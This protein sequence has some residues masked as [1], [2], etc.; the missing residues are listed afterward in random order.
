MRFIPKTL[1][2][3]IS[4]KADFLYRRNPEGREFRNKLK[5]KGDLICDKIQRKIIEEN[6]Y[7][8]SFKIENPNFAIPFHTAKRSQRREFKKG[9]QN[10]KNAFQWGQENFDPSNFDEKFIRYLAA[11]IVPEIY[12]GDLAQYRKDTEGTGFSGDYRVTP[13]YPQKLTE[14]EIPRFV[15]KLQENFKNDRGIMARIKTSIDSHFHIARMHPFKDG[16]GRTARIF[17]DII[18][19]HYT[20]PSPIIES[21]EKEIYLRLIEAAVFDWKHLKN[22]GEIPN[23]ATDGERNFYT[24]I[25]GKVNLS[26]DKIIEKCHGDNLY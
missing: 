22:S 23:G 12:K 13:P 26:F 8:N 11:S 15:A 21:G 17:Q 10:I 6:A 1:A 18:L 19:N 20:I 7:I 5:G 2:K 24:F 3:E 9:V 25:A 4:D 14:L 16:N